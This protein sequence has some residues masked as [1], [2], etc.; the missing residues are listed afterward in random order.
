MNEWI[1]NE[2]L[3]FSRQI[4]YQ[5]LPIRGKHPIIIAVTVSQ[6]FALSIAFF[7]FPDP[8]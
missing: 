3:I 6:S 8:N 7:I 5:I 1:M 4:I 2:S